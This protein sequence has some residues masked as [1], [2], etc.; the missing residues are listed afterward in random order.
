MDDFRRQMADRIPGVR[1]PWRTRLKLWPWRTRLADLP[2]KLGWGLGFCKRFPKYL[3]LEE[4]VTASEWVPSAF[5]WMA[6]RLRCRETDV[7][8]LVLSGLAKRRTARPLLALA[9]WRRFRAAWLAGF[10]ERRPT[11]EEQSPYRRDAA[12]READRV[13]QEVKK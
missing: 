1:L 3:M 5:A 10:P 4:L 6:R 13:E 12:L 7:K 2:R 9:G 8:S 11:G